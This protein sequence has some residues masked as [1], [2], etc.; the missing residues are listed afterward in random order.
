MLV[1]SVA[2][3]ARPLA[4]VALAFPCVAQ[5]QLGGFIKRAVG[6]KVAEKAAEK[7]AEKMKDP[8]ADS[9]GVGARGGRADRM[10]MT[11]AA[12]MASIQL[13]GDTLERALRGLDALA[14]AF[15]R[16]DSL[17]Q[18][19]YDVSRR[20]TELSESSGD[21]GSRYREKLGTIQD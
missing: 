3:R 13:T 10:K 16:R 15:A 12:P 4:F 5:A 2:R 6:E 19:A 20:V 7:V 9:G 21:L 1:H 8:R 14:R 11:A 17:G 18:A